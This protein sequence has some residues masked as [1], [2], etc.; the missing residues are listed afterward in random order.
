MTSSHPL[1]L[2][3]SR[4]AKQPAWAWR[5]TLDD[6]RGEQ[7]KWL[8]KKALPM[9]RGVIRQEAVWSL[10]L[11]VMGY[12]SSYSERIPI[13]HLNDRVRRLFPAGLPPVYPFQELFLEIQRTSEETG[14]A[15]DP[16]WRG[17][18]GNAPGPW[19]WDPY[20]DERLLERV[21]EVYTGAVEGYGQLVAEWF[22]KFA[23][24]LDTSVTLPAKLDG[25]LIRP[26]PNAPAPWISWHLE[27]LPYGSPNV[28]KI[29]FSESQQTDVE[30]R[31]YTR[32]LWEKLKLLRPH[33]ADWI[34]Y[35]FVR[36]VLDIFGAT[37]ATDLAYGWL[38][39]D[40]KRVSFQ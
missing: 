24:W 13:A 40:L 29:V 6:L 14:G 39:D 30:W 2:R 19:V 3:G 10:A 37:P 11:K 7:K 26:R 18:D 1:K 20:S 25:E 4:P 17:P 5:W 31:A 22:P 15:I 12:G 9:K 8:E 21:R 23:A 35:H 27:P 28:V 38:I 16:P 36:S 33:A 32:E 34:G